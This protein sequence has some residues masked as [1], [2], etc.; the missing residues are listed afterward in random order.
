MLEFLNFP[1]GIV[2]G[3]L[4]GSVPV[5]G[6]IW[7]LMRRDERR[8]LRRWEVE[9]QLRAVEQAIREERLPEKEWVWLQPYREQ[10]AEITREARRR[11]GL[12]EEGPG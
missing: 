4:A 12:S 8:I 7:W 10:Q 9:R 5:W 11:L 1:L 3:C 6:L 2:L